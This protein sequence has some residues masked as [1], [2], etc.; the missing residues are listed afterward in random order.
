VFNFLKKKSPYKVGRYG[1]TYYIDHR[2]ALDKHIIDH[3]ILQDWSVNQIN[4]LVNSNAVIFD[5]GANVG[6]TTLPFAKQV[7]EGMVYAFEPDRENFEQLSKNVK[8]NSFRNIS[9]HKIALQDNEKQTSSKLFI[10][11]A[12]DDDKLINRGLST[13]E[14]FEIHN[15]DTE[16]INTTTIDRFVKE[17]CITKLDLIKIDVEGSESKVIEG[18]K[19]TIEKF[20]PII[21][22]EY[23]TIIDTLINSPNSYKTFNMLDLLGYRQYLIKNES[24]LQLVK[25]YDPKIEAANVLAIHNQR[26]PTKLKI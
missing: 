21:I 4:N 19:S 10:R 23:S 15:K 22:Y 7:P 17:S 8:I 18:G 26:S 1:I 3:G 16:V 24:D 14:K 11:R 20:H 12:I 2:S 6:L 9:L 13:L 25:E 5:I